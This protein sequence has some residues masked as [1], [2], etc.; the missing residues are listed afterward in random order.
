MKVRGE[1]FPQG[2]S[3]NYLTKSYFGGLFRTVFLFSVAATIPKY[4]NTA[5]KARNRTAVTP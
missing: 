3:L 1:F 4:P 2:E 5:I